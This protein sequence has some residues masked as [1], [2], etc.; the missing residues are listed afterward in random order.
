VQSTEFKAQYQKKIKKEYKKILYVMDYNSAIKINEIMSF[1]GKWMQLEVIMLNKPDSEDNY[2]MFSLAYRIYIFKNDINAK[3][4][5]FCG[6]EEEGGTQK[7][8]M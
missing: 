5:L 6:G 4:G 3:G 1:T 7:S 2:H 8:V